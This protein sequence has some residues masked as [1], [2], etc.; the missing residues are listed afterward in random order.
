LTFHGDIGILANFFQK[1][2]RKEVIG[3]ISNFYSDTTPLLALCGIIPE[4]QIEKISL[5]S[6]LEDFLNV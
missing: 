2:K 3:L 1:K 5:I 6:I 4:Y